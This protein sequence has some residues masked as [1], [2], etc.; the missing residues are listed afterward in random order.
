LP[1]SLNLAFDHRKILTDGVEYART[2]LEHSSLATAFCAEVFTIPELQQ[3][4]EAVWG[5]P[6][7]P[8]NFFRKVQGTPGFIAAT[9]LVRKTQGGRPARLFRAGPSRV[10]NPPMA[11]G[12]QL[13]GGEGGKR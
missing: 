11:R 2:K 8:R 5:A 12:A 13:L 1:P 7:D 10:L 9:G 6:L 3:V 4:Y